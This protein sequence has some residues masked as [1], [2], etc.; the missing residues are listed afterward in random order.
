MLRFFQTATHNLHTTLHNLRGTERTMVELYSANYISLHVRETNFAAF[1]LYRDTLQFSEHG[2]EPKYYA[3]GENAFDMRK[4]L[5][6]EMFGLAPIPKG[7]AGSKEGSGGASALLDGS[8]EAASGASP[9]LDPGK[10]DMELI[11]R[12]Q[13]AELD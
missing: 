5:T 4:K 1:H 3:D 10:K 8:A 7:A 13:A 6:R 11:A 9:D 12:M 2:I